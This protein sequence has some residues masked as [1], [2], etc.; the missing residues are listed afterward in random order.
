MSGREKR[1]KISVGVEVDGEF[2]FYVLFKRE[3]G[4]LRGR[5]RGR[6]EGREGGRKGKK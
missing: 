3:E 1:K 5:G 4:R 6:E 2:G